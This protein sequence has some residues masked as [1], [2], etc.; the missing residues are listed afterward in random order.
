MKRSILFIALVAVVGLVFLAC[1]TPAQK[2][3]KLFDAGN[4]EEVVQQFGNDPNLSALVAQAKEKLAEKLLAEGKFM[5]ILAMYP[6][7]KAATDARNNL[8]EALFAEGK[9]QEVIEK[10]G[11]TPAAQKARLAIEQARADSIA[12]AQPA[13]KDGKAPAM[14]AKE[15]A[16]QAEYDR[17]MAMKIDRAR[18]AAL[19]TFVK[20]AQYA[21]TSAQKKAQAALNLK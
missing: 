14:S 4:Y 17:I 6:E 21:G 10:Y 8:A 16:A 7:S 5:D 3:Q 11:D 13:P 2:A 12:K 1:S 9:F 18:I 15:K 20:D 19:Q